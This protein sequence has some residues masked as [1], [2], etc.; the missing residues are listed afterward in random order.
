MKYSYHQLTD[1]GKRQLM[2][3]LSLELSD[4]K[5][6]ELM[7]NYSAE[8]LYNELIKVT[9]ERSPEAVDFHIKNLHKF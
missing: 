2:R 5:I 7:E 6:A 3:E 4:K 1:E 8:E 9:E